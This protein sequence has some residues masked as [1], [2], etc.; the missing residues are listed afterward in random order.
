MSPLGWT[1]LIL[2]LLY[3]SRPIA[4][5]VGRTVGGYTA[6]ASP[7]V[8][9]APQSAPAVH[10]LAACYRALDLQP[11]ATIEEVRAS[12]IELVKVWHPDRFGND[13]KL[14]EKANRKMSEINDAYQKI[15]ASVSPRA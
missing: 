14:R 13:E 11:T 5:N 15:M 8:A 12:Y 2:L 10:P 3:Y 1:L 6:P 7:P 4:R 9:P